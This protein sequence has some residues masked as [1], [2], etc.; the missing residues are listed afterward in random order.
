MSLVAVMAIS[1]NG[2]HVNA[3]E[4][5]EEKAARF[6]ARDRFTY[7]RV[8]YDLEEYPDLYG[9]EDSIWIDRDASG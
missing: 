4:T 8:L 6:T 3:E 1:F 9:K 2:F 5:K 7:N